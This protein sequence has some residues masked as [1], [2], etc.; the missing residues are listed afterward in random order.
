MLPACSL[1]SSVISI[2]SK[3]GLCD[4]CRKS[5]WQRA[6]RGTATT[7]GETF[8]CSGCRMPT[9]RASNYQVQCQ[10]CAG[11]KGPSYSVAYRVR[12]HG[13][14]GR[15]PRLHVCLTCSGPVV[16]KAH[17]RKYCDECRVLARQER[18]RISRTRPEGYISHRISAGI[19]QSLRMAKGGHHWETLVGF[20]LADLMSHLEAQFLP[21][22]SWENRRSWHIDHRRPLC[23]Y[24]FKTPDCLQFREAWAIT[25]L[26][27]LWA[28]DNLAKGG[29]WN[30][31]AD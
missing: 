2:H 12:K 17:N 22:M 20:T 8:P 31:P 30:P 21:G 10:E 15:K 19:K 4:K 18:V 5:E 16:S 27:P 25:N 24:E 29:R 9:V 26:Q 7:R 3:S 28:R 13:N 23:S 1:C 11:K 6:K 14:L